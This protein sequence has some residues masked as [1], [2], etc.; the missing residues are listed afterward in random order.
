MSRDPEDELQA[1]RN[2]HL[3]RKLRT[4]DSPQQTELIIDGNHFV[5]FSSNDY[6]GL[7]QNPDIITA[8]KSGLDQWGAGS[9]ASRL[10]CGTQRPHQKLEHLLAELKSCEAALTFSS[11][12]ATAVGTIT[13]LAKKGDILILDKLCHA[14]LI[15]GARLSGATLRIYPHNDIDRLN[16]HLLWAVD[17]ISDTDGRIIIITE[18]VFSMDGDLCPLNQIVSLKEKYGALLLLDEAHAFGVIGKGIGLAD[19]LDLA[20]QVDLQMGTL[21]KAIG[22]SGGYLCSSRSIIDLLINRS[23]SF[24]YSTAPPAATAEAALTAVNLMV[25]DEGKHLRARAQAN[26]QQLTTA[27]DQIEETSSPIL[28]LIVGSSEEAMDLSGQLFEDGFLI[29][30][31]RYPTVPRNE[32]RLRITLSAAHTGEQI[33]RLISSLAKLLPSR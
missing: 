22:L 21:S 4:I 17:K 13:A 18:S 20:D 11:G 29:P 10:I 28:P 16:S 25:G 7:S 2:D 9:G 27:I 14:S 1:L 8:Y 24:I 5:N 23:R 15:D 30:A 19:D 3:F 26:I 32:A 33:S 31:I 12:Y 6:L